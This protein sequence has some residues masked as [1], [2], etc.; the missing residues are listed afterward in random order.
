MV[1]GIA[2]LID[3]M[4]WPVFFVTVVLAG[5]PLAL[6]HELGHAIVA[7]NRQPGRVIV[8]VGADKPATSFEIGRITFR[9]HPVLRPWRFDAVCA[10]ERPRRRADAVL[11]ALGGPAASLLAGLVAVAA[12]RATDSSST[13]HWVIVSIACETLFSTL[14][15]LTPMLLTDSRGLTLRTDGALVVAALRAHPTFFA[16]PPQRQWFIRTTETPPVRGLDGRV[17]RGE[18]DPA[19]SATDGNWTLRPPRPRDQESPG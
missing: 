11:I 2:N 5:P 3:A 14:V 6:I 8:R 12:A 13:L 4:P 18:P 9:L 16:A 17:V 7:V 1:Q 15:C 10:H 19:P